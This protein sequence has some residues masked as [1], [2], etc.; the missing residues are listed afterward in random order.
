MPEAMQEQAQ[1]R[2]MD[3]KAGAH[4]MMLDAGV[5][6]VFHAP[7]QKPPS[8]SGLPG[9]RVTRAP[10]VSSDIVE[11]STFEADGWMG[12]MNGAALVRVRR[13][14]AGVMVTT[15]QEP[16]S[17]QE[18]PRLQV[19]RLI[20]GV[21]D[22]NQEAE[23]QAAASASA[24]VIG[25]EGRDIVAHVQRHGDVKQSFGEWVG[26][27][28]SQLWVEGFAINTDRITTNDIEYQAVLG[29]GWLSPW[30]EGGQF[31]GSRGMSLPIL[32]LRVRL[33]GEA[34]SQWSLR[35]SAT[36]TDGTR[37]GPVDGA[38]DAL[39]AESLAPLEA[40]RIELIPAKAEATTPKASET[41]DSDSQSKTAE[42]AVSK[43]ASKRNSRS[44]RR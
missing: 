40:F 9:V 37:L 26:T 30:V 43:S 14:P 11:I 7:G 35:V 22:A 16:E 4:V 1:N 38:D 28:G 25:E 15:Y 29:R 10:G 20:S 18:G 44:R 31:C 41:Q 32:G 8:A 42:K 24:E 27:P 34:A 36:F 17:S 19:M 6:C 12:G 33:R 23:G 3:L 2:V 21:Y 5:F 39:E 13:G